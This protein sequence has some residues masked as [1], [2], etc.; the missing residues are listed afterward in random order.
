MIRINGDYKH[1]YIIYIYIYKYNLIYIIM[2]LIKIKHIVI[3]KDIESNDGFINNFCFGCNT[4]TENK[5]K[6]I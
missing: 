1:I 5:D 3:N 6:F 2:K 4:D